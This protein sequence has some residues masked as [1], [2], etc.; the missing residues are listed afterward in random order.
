MTFMQD[1]ASAL[2]SKYGIERGALAR[3]L[4]CLKGIATGDA[5]GKQTENLAREDVLR[6]YPNG[7]NGFDGPSGAP[8]PRYVGNKKHGW[9][10]GETTDDTER[11]LA[12][13]SAIIQEKGVTHATVGLELLKCRKS[14]H[15]G[16]ASLW[17]FHTAG[18]PARV[19]RGH[20]GCGAAVRVAPV[21]ILYR[22]HRLQELV[23]AAKEASISTHAGTNA[24]AAA[25]ATAAAVSAAVEGMTAADVIDLAQQAAVMAETGGTASGNL[26]EALLRV[27]GELSQRPRLD[28]T[29]VA[30]RVFPGP[31]VDHRA[32][33]SR[34]RHHHNF[35]SRGHL[36]GYE[37]RR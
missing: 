10:F 6:W 32:A 13:A 12:V 8:I 19:A 33:G 24:L 4:G 26:A 22:P 3:S 28:P 9:V 1:R 2:R 36:A 7:L 29:E 18:D 11:S 16:V 21:G 34:S 27:R 35:R 30:T 37:H 25:A 31:H 15:P 5:I 17:E 20:D 14:V 23:A